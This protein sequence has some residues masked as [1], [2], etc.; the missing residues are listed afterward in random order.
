MVTR[1]TGL[2]SGIDIDQWVKDLVKAERTR[3]DKWYQK[4]QILE[5]QREEYRN[6]NTKLLAL[7]NATFDLKL[8]GSFQA[9]TATSSDT[10]VL[11]ATAG[12]SAVAGT[13]TLKVHSPASGVYK[14]S[15]DALPDEQGTGRTKTLAEQFGLT[16]TVTFTLEGTV[17]G[18]AVSKDFS[19]DTSTANIYTVV[20]E[21]NRAGIGIKASYDSTLNRF[22][23][24][25][26]S[27]GSSS[28]L[29]VKADAEGFLTG[30]LKLDVAVGADEANA[31]R[32]TDAVIDF[33]DVT[34]LA[35]SSNQFT[36]AGITFNLKNTSA[37]PVTVN[38]AA[39]T[40][41]V[42]D[43]IKAWVNA[44][45]DAVELMFNK[46]KEERYRDYQPLTDEQKKE[47]K[48]SDIEKW[49]A[50]AKSGLLKGDSLLYGVYSRIRSAAM[51]RVEGLS[52]AYNNL[53]AIGITT[54]SYQEGGKLYIDETRLRQALIADPEG[55]TNLFTAS[56]TGLAV[57]L[58]D[59]VNSS[60][61]L[62][63]DKAGSSTSYYDSSS[64][65]R[66]ISRVNTTISQMEKR[67]AD[68]E[69]RYYRQF[70]AMEKA[71]QRMNQQSMWLA[72]QFGG[73]SQQQ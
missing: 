29:H 56:G 2:A 32:G 23:L 17:N 36:V 34:G 71:I 25:T 6:I 60:M 28:K 37:A 22:F 7:R 11:T 40:D 59:E 42:I 41:A 62:I 51:A 26:D 57:K 33:N 68:L 31:Y 18:E 9:K 61:Q 30:S 24:M 45:N 20:G 53:S 69:D 3:V 14:S 13:Y 10:G 43:K 49:E 64:I 52:T 1:I 21:I 70:E 50:K 54:G 58:Y 47:M 39:D 4:K 8:Q 67:L 44:Y 72:M 15:T 38:V 27:T 48:D 65:G 55:V 5:W 66:E 63:T 19:F 16:G 35:F 73:S 46:L 12:G